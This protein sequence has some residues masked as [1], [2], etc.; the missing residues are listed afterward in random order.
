[1]A[2]AVIEAIDR[3]RAAF[4]AKV[5]TPK[6]WRRWFYDQDDDPN[7]LASRW[8]ADCSYRTA[9]DV[10]RW[11]DDPTTSEL[12]IDTYHHELFIDWSTPE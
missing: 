4:A 8:H 1:M 9:K 11:A 7:W 5:V 12:H 6:G 3:K 2:V 10:I